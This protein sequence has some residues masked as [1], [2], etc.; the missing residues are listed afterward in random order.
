VLGPLAGNAIGMGARKFLGSETGKLGDLATRG[1]KAPS[2]EAM[3]AA[4]V[5]AG[6]MS[7]TAMSDLAELQAQEAAA[8]EVAA[9]REATRFGMPSM[10]PLH[11][12]KAGLDFFRMNAPRAIARTAPLARG[13]AGVDAASPLSTEGAS[14]LFQA[15][16]RG[17][18]GRP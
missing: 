3:D 18:G 8:A 9:A 15:A 4:T 2:A 11:P 7:R 12:F 14:L 5:E 13:A 10:S 1:T 16:M 6:S 17:H